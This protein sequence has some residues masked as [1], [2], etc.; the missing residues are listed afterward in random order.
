VGK[1][2]DYRATGLRL[3]DLHKETSHRNTTLK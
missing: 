2:Y 1:L 3:K